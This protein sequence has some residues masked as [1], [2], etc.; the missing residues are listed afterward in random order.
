MHDDGAEFGLG[1]QE[2]LADHKQV[3]A[4]LIAQC[5]AGAQAGMDEQVI[6]LLMRQHQAAEEGDVIGRERFG[7]GLA[8][9]VFGQAPA[10]QRLPAARP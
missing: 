4:H 8:R 1:C 7:P 5:D 6:A 9:Q 2:G 10:R 3:L